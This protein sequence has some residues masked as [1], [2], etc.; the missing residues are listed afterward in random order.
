MLAGI[1]RTADGLFEVRMVKCDLE[2]HPE[3]N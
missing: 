1:S 3:L 2:A